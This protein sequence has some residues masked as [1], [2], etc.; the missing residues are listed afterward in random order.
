MRKGL[1]PVLRTT[2]H[3]F[4]IGLLFGPIMY[5]VDV[6][7]GYYSEF[8]NSIIFYWLWYFIAY[9]FIALLLV[10]C[11]HALK[12]AFHINKFHLK[13]LLAAVL[14]FLLAFAICRYETFNNNYKQALIMGVSFS[15]LG[16]AYVW[17]ESKAIFLKR[18]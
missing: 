8:P 15:V 1:K 13:V 2:L 18:P 3:L 17:L 14:C 12:K 9:I 11:Y 6:A 7:L 5:S 10:I 4:I 16:L